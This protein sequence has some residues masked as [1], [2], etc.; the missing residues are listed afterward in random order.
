MRNELPL[1]ISFGQ[2]VNLEHKSSA[3]RVRPRTVRVLP[4]PFHITP[5]PCHRF[6]FT[7]TGRRVKGVEWVRNDIMF[8]C[9]EMSLFTHLNDYILQQFL[10]GIDAAALRKG[11]RRHFRRLGLRLPTPHRCSGRHHCRW[12]IAGRGPSGACWLEGRRCQTTTEASPP[13][14]E[15]SASRRWRRRK[16]RPCR[17]SRCASI[18]PQEFISQIFHS[19]LRTPNPKLYDGRSRK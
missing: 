4:I 16:T 12:R 5:A 3:A 19:A 8:T 13:L 11:A 9:N 10:P 1:S 6:R 18:R 15:F 17:P 2:G 14:Q 7:I